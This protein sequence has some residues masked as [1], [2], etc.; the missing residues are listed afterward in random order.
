MVMNTLTRK[1]LRSL[2]L[3]KG[4][5]IAVVS[6]V[7]I[8]I[9]LYIAMSN[10]YQNLQKSQLDFYA[11]KD[12]ADYY[13]QVVKAPERITKQIEN[14][15]GVDRVSGRITEDLALIKTDDSR[16][17][18]RIVT[19]EP[20]DKEDLNKLYI[21]TGRIFSSSSSGGEMEAVV[22][23][24]FMAAN[25]LIPGDSISIV[26]DGRQI[27][28]R[29][30]GSA[31]GPEFIYVVKDA[32][33]MF[34]DPETFGII[35]LPQRQVQQAFNMS[36][37]INQIL[38]RFDPGLDEERTIK[39][40]EEIL[41]PYGLLASYPRDDQISHAMLEAE[42]DGLKSIAGVLPVI[43]LLIAA[44]I[45]FVI[46]RRMIK[47][48]RSQI[49]IMKAL[50]YTSRE[51]KSHYIIYSL[52][53]GFCGALTGTI[54][55]IL[56][57]GYITDMF[58]LYFNLPEKI[59]GYNLPVI[60]NAFL[61]SIIIAAAAGWSAANAVTGIQPAESMRPETPKIGSH[62][63]LETAASIWSRL[64][65]QWKMSLR[66][67]R[68]NR[69]R[70]AVTLLGTIFA[71][72]LMI[73]AL[74]TNDSVDYMMARHFDLDRTYDL[75]VSFAHP[76]K[77]SEL[78][79]LSRLNGVERVEGYFDLPVK[80]SYQ[81][82]SENEL[83]TAYPLDMQLKHV[84]DTNNQPVQ[85]PEAG[86]LINKNTAVKLGVMAGDEV[87]IETLLPQGPK[88]IEKVK[89][90]GV[91]TQMFGGGSYLN[92]AAA[93][94]IIKEAG[95]VTG[96]MVK[97]RPGQ[98]ERVEKDINAM[99]KVSSLLNREKERENIMS[100]ME[101][102]IFI[103]GMLVLFALILGFAIIYNSSTISFHERE[104]EFAALKVIGFQSSEVSRIILQEN[105]LQLILGLIIGLP[106]GGILTRV[107]LT[108][109]SNELYDMPAAVYPLSYLL[110]ALGVAVFVVLAYKIAVRGID[111]LD[112]VEVLKNRD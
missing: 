80:I 16:A 9:M 44:A 102:T 23:P 72:I 42:I 76:L 91:N 41:S 78:L 84:F 12:F 35:M 30:V 24:Q 28:V 68:R 89:I 96:A 46:I 33:T 32:V 45:Q 88:H 83:L 60:G 98:E 108:S 85:L 87:T 53:V 63:L 65:P 20:E 104:Q 59:L 36:G 100:M 75:Q 69:G 29:V 105:L 62:S 93:N 73:M 1:L 21:L 25:G 64:S 19:Y 2:I 6:V 56:L 48:Q 55:G 90:A 81:G 40:I 106:A 79:E 39:E 103:V 43:F 67:I 10:S 107:Y 52:L 58:A 61:L 51:I 31:T 94:R 38:I 34:P 111:R 112:L 57:S 70:F 18:A 50:G 95:L 82:R 66:S 11:K 17:S 13:F 101:P 3:R 26:K 37:Q 110:S 8:G 47:T 71:V 86:I 97:I 49:G 15:P 14:L 92:L 4:Q 7:A 22:D 99:L 27:N 54:F 74:G 109:L 5:F 77:T